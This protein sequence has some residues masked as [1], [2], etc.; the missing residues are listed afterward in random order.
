MTSTCTR[1][2]L[3]ACQVVGGTEWVH[4]A[5]G[6]TNALCSRVQCSDPIQEAAACCTAGVHAGPRIRATTGRL[7]AARWI[8]AR[9]ARARTHAHLG[10]LAEEQDA[11]GGGAVEDEALRAVEHELRE[12]LQ[13]GRGH[14][15]LVRPHLQ[16]AQQQREVCG[17]QPV[18]QE[19]CED[20]TIFRLRLV[21]PVLARWVPAHW[22]AVRSH[23]WPANEVSFLHGRRHCARLAA[24]G[25]R[26]ICRCAALQV[27]PQR[28][29]QQAARAGAHTVGAAAVGGLRDASQVAQ[30]AHHGLH[31]HAA[32]QLCRR[33][34]AS[35]RALQPLQH[36]RAST[37]EE[38]GNLLL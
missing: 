16:A 26:Q 14:G 35:T 19:A 37:S 2:C 5:A 28:W 18:E 38:A 11:V 7:T 12:Q 4:H 9:V 29:T 15:R 23:S 6:A 22:A 21:S 36:L 24:A 3:S 10:D 33:G 17:V 27:L 31:S 8:T 25:A 32:A 20:M 13:Q 30:Q 1:G 34:A